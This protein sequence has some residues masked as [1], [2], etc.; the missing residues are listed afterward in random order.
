MARN[1]APWPPEDREL[2]KFRGPHLAVDVALMTV[3]PDPDTEQPTLAALLVRRA[4]GAQKCSSIS[5]CTS[6]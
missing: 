2:A 4:E 1:E 5:L 3:A 6:T